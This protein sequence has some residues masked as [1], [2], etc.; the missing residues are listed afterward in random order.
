MS[1]AACAFDSHYVNA[2]RQ[3][4]PAVEA[5]FV[6]HFSPILLRVLRGKVRSADQA[7]EV[8]QETFLRVLETVRS[9]P[10]VHKPERFEVFVFSVCNNVVRESYRE[11]YRSVA[12]EDLEAEPVADFPNPYALA[13]AEETRQQVRQILS[14][15]ETQEKGILQ[16]MF[17]DEHDKDEICRK[18]GVTRN[19][20]RVLLWRA[21]KRF[22]MEERN[23]ARHN[24]A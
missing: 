12:L 10:G 17:L 11:Q 18:L 8:R 7:R 5:H 13:L 2:L 9:G 4:D 1:S 19:Y 3:G 24:A 20:L 6:E 14:Q 22:A 23:F 15:L 16:A 21:K